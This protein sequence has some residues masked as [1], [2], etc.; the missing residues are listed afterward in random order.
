MNKFP[1]YLQMKQLDVDVYHPIRWSCDE[2][3]TI[4]WLTAKMD[5]VVSPCNK[6]EGDQGCHQSARFE[7]PD[8]FGALFPD[9]P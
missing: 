2:M 7:F 5:S 8:F 6:P 1:E 9:F 4:H 3:L